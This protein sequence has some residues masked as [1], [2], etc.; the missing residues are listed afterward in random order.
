LIEAL[1]RRARSALSAAADV[2]AADRA[3]F[4]RGA[5]R[6]ARRIE[7]ERTP[8]GDALALLVRAGVAVA[9]GR[10][11]AATTLLTTAEQSLQALDMALHAASA[12]RHRGHLIGGEEGRRLILD[13]DTW[14]TAQRI[15]NPARMA[16]LLSPGSPVDH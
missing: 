13:A 9:R 2:P 7:R 11:D 3:A 12:R 15:R 8:W 14:M 16:A 4:I 5:E 1:D 6:D 10:V